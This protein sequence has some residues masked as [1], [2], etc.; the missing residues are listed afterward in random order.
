MTSELRRPGRINLPSELNYFSGDCT[1][2]ATLQ[3]IKENFIT[4]LQQSQYSSICVLPDCTAGNVGV[5][6]G[7][8]D[9]TV[10]RRKRRSV[11]ST[12]R[13]Q[14]ITDDIRQKR[15]LR[16]EA[17][18]KDFHHREKRSTHTHLVT[19]KFDFI[20][21][22]P[23]TTGEIDA[24]SLYTNTTDDLF[25][26]YYH[27]KDAIDNGQFDQQIPG[28][29]LEIDAASFE[30]GYEYLECPEGTI[31]EFTSFSCSMYSHRFS[32]NEL[33]LKYDNNSLI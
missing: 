25:A 7:P 21:T 32:H 17:L 33:H 1:D 8:V 16:N 5:T 26:M 11:T 24:D 4:L 20:V 15:S 2:P 18:Q 13:S 22:I 12:P 28:L 19:V 3:T 10:G 31:E 6:C 27:V 14:R 23:Y 30:I 9:N 29:T